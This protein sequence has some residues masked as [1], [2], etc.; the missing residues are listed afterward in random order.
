[1]NDWSLLLSLNKITHYF[2]QWTTGSEL[3]ELTLMSKNMRKTPKK[4]CLK[5][6][7]SGKK[8]IC[9]FRR[10]R[11]NGQVKF[12]HGAPKKGLFVIF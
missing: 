10:L 12:L 9:V 1:M 6:K 11:V 3:S 8:R 2:K 5:L 7:Q 4:K